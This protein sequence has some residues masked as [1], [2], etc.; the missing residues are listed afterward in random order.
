MYKS[1]AEIMVDVLHEY[2][3]SIVWYGSLDLI[4]ECWS[5][6]NKGKPQKHPRNVIQAVLNGIDRSKLFS[7]KNVLLK[8][9]WV[10]FYKIKDNK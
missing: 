5:R 6:K 2:N 10:R 3:Q 1:Y 9:H 7:R 8:G 4:H